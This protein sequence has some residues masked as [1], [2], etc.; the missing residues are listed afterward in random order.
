MVCSLMARTLRRLAA[1]LAAAT[2]AAPPGAGAAVI[3]V[4]GPC[5]VA[6]RPVPLTGAQFISGALVSIAGGAHGSARV[7]AAGS[8]ATQLRA[9]RVTTI[10]PRLVTITAT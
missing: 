9:P 6:G 5:F 2:L 8:F 1:A 7:D 4:Q 10:A 3:A